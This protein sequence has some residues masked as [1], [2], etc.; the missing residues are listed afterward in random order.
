[1]AP[2]FSLLGVLATLWPALKKGFSD[3]KLMEWLLT[4][5]Y[6]IQSSV[7]KISGKQ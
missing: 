1:M 5:L 4:S 7:M 3:I 6:I 2:K